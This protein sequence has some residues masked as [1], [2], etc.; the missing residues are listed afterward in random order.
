M[1]PA[2]TI[3]GRRSGWAFLLAALLLS[4]LAVADDPLVEVKAESFFSAKGKVQWRYLLYLPPEYA[5]DRDRSWPL[6]IWLHGR[7][8]RGN[9]LSL[10]RKY[11]PPSFFGRRKDFPFVAVFPQ[12]PEGSWPSESLDRFLTEMLDKYRVDEDRVILSGTSLGAMGAWTFAADYPQHFAAVVP[13]AA[14]G[15]EHAARKL[16]HVP[17]WAFHG[18]AD[19]IVPIGP[20]RELIESLNAN[21]GKAR[22]TVVPGATH[23]SVIAPTYARDD[24]YEWMLSQKRINDG[25]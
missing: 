4:Q 23:G 15:P 1:S 25:Q 22:L 3:W 5:D 21:G 9:D 19:E 11:G 2:P 12:L 8:L 18:D 20:H 24:L 17:V 7:S 16:I 13:V 10:L 14:H 6:L